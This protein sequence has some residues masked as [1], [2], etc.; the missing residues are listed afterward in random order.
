MSLEGNVKAWGSYCYDSERLP[1]ALSE[2]AT[3][4]EIP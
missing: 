1:S 2:Q 3:E 4:P